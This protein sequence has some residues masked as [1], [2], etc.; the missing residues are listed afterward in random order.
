[1]KNI[2]A[3]GLACPQ[4]VI[5]TKKALDDNENVK[6]IVDNETAKLN[7]MKLAKSLGCEVSVK[8]DF[9]Q[10]EMSFYKKADEKLED[11]EKRQK[12]NR[13]VYVIGSNLLGK[14]SEELGKILM[15][16]FI[17]TLTQMEYP[18]S[19]IVFLNTGVYLTSVESE[20]IE[21][22]KQ[23][24]AKGSEIVSCGTCLNFYDLTDKL[25]VGEVSN[26]YEIVE[27]IVAGQNTVM[28]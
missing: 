25:G 15:K 20:S 28:I 24:T 16:G 26:M 14:G 7:L 19:K 6:T 18:P 23:L 17:Y 27:I 22:L 1:M 10:I 3:R 8:E 2:D 13:M 5:L 11:V 4:P 12:T 9:N 21:D